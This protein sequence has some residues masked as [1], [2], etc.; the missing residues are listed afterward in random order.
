M[1]LVYRAAALKEVREAFAWYLSEAGQRQA[2]IFRDELN[3]KVALLMV[4][5]FASLLYRINDV[6]RVI[7]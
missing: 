3:A 5:C 2:T 6:P 7:G 1:K 4:T